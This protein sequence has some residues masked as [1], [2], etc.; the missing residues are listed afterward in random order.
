MTA[1][2]CKLQRDRIWGRRPDLGPWSS[3]RPLARALTEGHGLTLP[4][5][6]LSAAATRAGDALQGIVGPSCITQSAQ[7]H[8]RSLSEVSLTGFG[9]ISP[10]LS[11]T[12]HI[13]A[14]SRCGTPRP[15]NYSLPSSSAAQWR[16]SSPVHNRIR[17]ARRATC[18]RHNHV[19]D[20]SCRR[21]VRRSDRHL[22]DGHADRKLADRRGD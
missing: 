17:K 1:R 3:V 11:C 6:G 13:S 19:A 10:T 15:L 12:A 2:R 16:A 14:G 8:W 4:P 21:G 5:H 20:L 9:P 22:P 18:L 7:D